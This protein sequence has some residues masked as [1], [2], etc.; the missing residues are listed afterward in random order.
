MHSTNHDFLENSSA[1]SSVLQVSEKAR[2]YLLRYLKSQEKA[3]GIRVSVE[4]AGC[5]GWKYKIDL[6]KTIEPDDYSFGL[7]EE[8]KIYIDP[9]S[10]NRIKGTL[11]D[12]NIEGLNEKIIFK[13][14][15]ARNTCGCGESFAV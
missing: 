7:D 5:S 15:Q 1:E 14:S 11:I 2:A 10:F 3:Q 4:N 9:L 12:L 8:Y 6:L 13:N